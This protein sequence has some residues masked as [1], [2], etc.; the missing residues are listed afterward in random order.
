MS[1][2]IEQRAEFQ[3]QFDELSKENIQGLIKELNTAVGTYISQGGLSQDSNNNPNYTTIANLTQRAENIKQRYSM[4]N[5]NILLHLKNNASDTNVTGLLTEN[6]ELQ[7]QINRLEKIQSEMKIDVESSVA[8]DKLLRSRDTAITPHQLFVLD[9][10]IRKGLIPYLW[11]ISVLFIGI[12]LVMLKM[13][14]PSL[15][16]NTTSTYSIY[17]MIMEFITNKVVIG[18][19]IASILIVI[20]FLSLKVAGVFG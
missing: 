8:R 16:I 14:M 18:S 2:W 10:P 9:R 7:K 19:L 3:K 6:G 5:N 13:N 17:Y 20:L 15:Q 12:G 1:S 11:V 4:L